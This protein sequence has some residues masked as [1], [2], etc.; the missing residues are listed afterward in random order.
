MPLTIQYCSDL[1]LEFPLNERFMHKYPLHVAGDILVL[2]GDIVPFT[3]LGKHNYF[4]DFCAANYVA[5]YW[6]P[7]NHEFYH[8]DIASRSGTLHE[9]IR[10][11]V[12]LVNNTTIHLQDIQLIFATLWSR[13]NIADQLPIERAM[14]DFHLIKNNGHKFTVHDVDQLHSEAIAFIKKEIAT[15]ASAKKIVVT[16]HL[17][18]FINYP[19]KYK[20]DILSQAFATE[21]AGLIESSGIHTWIYGHHHCNT[22]AFH[23]GGTQL[24]T[25][26]LGYVKHGE[27]TT[28]NPSAKITL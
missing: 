2:A 11:N 8:S 1:H 4:F 23:I 12:F 24:L 7:G 28:F 20:G 10:D 15:Q 27:H 14:S 25:N 3:L 18:T 21:Y 13:I 6:L 16:H 22:P 19:E 26:Q 17:P 5:T 9:Q